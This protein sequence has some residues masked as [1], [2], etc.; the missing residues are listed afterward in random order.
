MKTFGFIGVGNMGG[1]LAKAACKSAGAENVLVTDLLPEK[2]AELAK[3]TGC[4]AVSA[5][6]IVAT[7][8]Y[9]F[10]GAK[11]QGAA[12]LLAGLREG[13]AARGGS[14]TLVSMMAGV[15]IARIQEL[16]GV[17]A[18]II[19]IMP[20]TPANVGQGM[21]LYTSEGACDETVQDF[22]A[23]MSAAGKFDA[24]PETLF[25]AATAISGCGPAF[26]YM[27]LEAMADAGVVSGL[28]Y[29]KALTYAAQTMIGAAEMVLQSGQHPEALKNAVCSPAGSTIAGVHALEAA[30]FRGTLMDGV[31]AAYRKTQELGK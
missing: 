13:V 17:E 19:R 30:G 23:G 8:D 4:R 20:N 27:A 5:E 29:Q 26:L 16:L 7:A 1:A 18:P 2:A 15:T 24:I 25:D 22:L 31:L 12:G 3:A 6:E 28:S 21:I 9:L 10:L 11:P 14:L